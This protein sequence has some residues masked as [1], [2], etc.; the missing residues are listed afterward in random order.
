M[1]P[2]PVLWPSSISSRALRPRR[3]CRRWVSQQANR[4]VAQL[5]QWRPAEKVD[6]VVVNGFVRSVRSMKA[7]RFVSL[8][9]GSSLAP[10]QALVPADHAEGCERFFMAPLQSQVTDISPCS[11]AIGAAV[12]LTGSWVSSPGAAQSHELHVSKVEVL[13]PSDAKVRGM[14]F[15]AL[16]LPGRSGPPEPCH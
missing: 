15:P 1:R 16:H 11:L 12:R 8:G 2:A 5:L 13:G 4:S 9:D 10:L 14:L 7:H 6:D 3:V